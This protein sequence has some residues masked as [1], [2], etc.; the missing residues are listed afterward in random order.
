MSLADRLSNSQIRDAK[1]MWGETKTLG[2][3]AQALGKD[4]SGQPIGIY[5]LSPWLYA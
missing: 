5:H 1:R 3:I 4:S 2:E